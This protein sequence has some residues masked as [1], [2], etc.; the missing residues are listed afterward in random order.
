MGISLKFRDLGWKTCQTKVFEFQCKI[1]VAYEKG[2]LKEV[3]RLQHMLI[4]SFEARA[5][6][7]RRVV[8]NSGAKTPG[9]DGVIWKTDKEK[10]DTI[11]MLRDLSEY[12]AQ[13]VRRIYIPKANG[14]KR[15][16]GIPTMFD[17][18]VQ[19]LW[20]LAQVPIGE[21]TAD[22]RSYGFRQYR[23]V[24]DVATYLKQV[25]GAMYAKRWVLEADIKGFYDNLSHE[26]IFKNIPM[27]K[28]IL[29]EFLKAGFFLDNRT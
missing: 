19:A 17:R 10:I 8:K 4:R 2:D 6:A 15:P 20:M 5:I 18:A 13:P 16:L 27:E 23:G 26:W 3:T 22:T 29:K 7:V 28:K 21:S 11:L 12:K 25:L 24:Q 1:A 9:I 14:G